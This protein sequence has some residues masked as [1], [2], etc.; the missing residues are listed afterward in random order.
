MAID[1]VMTSSP[2]SK[3]MIILLSDG[4]QSDPDTPLPVIA[5]ERATGLGIVIHTVNFQQNLNSD[6]SDV[7]AET[8]GSHFDAVDG[9]DLSSVF[10]DLID[11]FSIRLAD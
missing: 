6:L 11:E 3:K 1:V 9:S 7:S 4:R 2:D 8:G 10:E 5:A